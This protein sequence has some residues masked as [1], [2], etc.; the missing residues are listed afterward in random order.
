[1]LKDKLI[2]I[3]D[4]LFNLLF[5]LFDL[6]IVKIKEYITKNNVDYNLYISIF[7]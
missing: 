3:I 7:V 2:I 1:M 5:F 4:I 6:N